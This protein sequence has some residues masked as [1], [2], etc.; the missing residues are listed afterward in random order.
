MSMAFKRTAGYWSIGS[1]NISFAGK[2]VS[3]TTGNQVFDQDDWP[4]DTRKDSLYG[5]MRK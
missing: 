2:N 3:D 5:T 1:W 4:M